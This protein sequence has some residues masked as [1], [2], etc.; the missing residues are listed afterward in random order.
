MAHKMIIVVNKDFLLKLEYFCNDI[1]ALDLNSWTWAKLNARGTPPSRVRGSTTWVYNG[2]V[3]GFGG[4]ISLN[5][6]MT[7]SNQ[8]FCIL[9]GAPQVGNG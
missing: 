9:I 5:P 1:Y 2:K 4:L 7:F 3:Y 6:D 8:L